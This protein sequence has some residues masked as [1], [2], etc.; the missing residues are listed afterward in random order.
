VLVPQLYEEKCKQLDL[1][2]QDEASL[3]VGD[4]EVEVEVEAEAEAKTEVE[5][6]EKISNDDNHVVEEKN[7][8]DDFSHDERSDHD[9]TAI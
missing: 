4:D 7:V 2:A 3:A 9:D 6:D 8:E 1:E 5:A